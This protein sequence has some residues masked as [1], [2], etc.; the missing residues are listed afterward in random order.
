MD[1]I[2]EKALKTMDD[3]L[4]AIR[5]EADTITCQSNTYDEDTKVSET[6][7]NLTQAFDLIYRNVR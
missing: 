3:I 5:V 4:D 2:N 6:I 7:L 1:E